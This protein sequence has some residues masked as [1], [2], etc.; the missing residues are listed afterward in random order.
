MCLTFPNVIQPFGC[1]IN[2]ANYSHAPSSNRLTMTNTSSAQQCTFYFLF[3]HLTK[4]IFKIMFLKNLAMNVNV[5][6]D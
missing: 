4:N 3:I 2:E 6:R 1:Q 5:L